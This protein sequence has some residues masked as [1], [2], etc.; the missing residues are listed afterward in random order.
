MTKEYMELLL[1]EAA[2]AHHTYEATLGHPDE[3]W[4]GW[5]AQHMVEQLDRDAATLDA[6]ANFGYRFANH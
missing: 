6:P 1:R 5:Y 4:Q 2:E 3:N